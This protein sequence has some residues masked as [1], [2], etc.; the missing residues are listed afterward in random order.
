MLTHCS[1]PPHIMDNSTFFSLSCD[2]NPSQNVRVE[3][4]DLKLRERK[5]KCRAVVG[6]GR[7]PFKGCLTKGGGC[8]R[9]GP[10][11][12]DHLELGTQPQHNESWG[13]LPRVSVEGAFRNPTISASIGEKRH[14]VGLDRWRAVLELAGSV[15]HQQLWRKQWQF[16]KSPAGGTEVLGP[17]G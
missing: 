3:E 10:E 13:I 6:A 17:P 1:P 16:L 11:T 5:Y 9:K 4:K 15:L 14:K 12:E 2:P 8:R 7:F